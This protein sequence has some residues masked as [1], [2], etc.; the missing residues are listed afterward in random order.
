M[1]VQRPNLPGWGQPLLGGTPF[2][3]D[4]VERIPDDG[5]RY[6]LYRGMLIRMAANMASLIR[7]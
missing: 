6:E 4:D 3:V 1:A 7:R 2:T 5:F